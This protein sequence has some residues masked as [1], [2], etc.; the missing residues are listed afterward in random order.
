MVRN[1]MEVDG[2]DGKVTCI[3]K[4][5]MQAQH[6]ETIGTTGQ[7]VDCIIKKPDGVGNKS[8]VQMLEVPGYDLEL[9]YAKREG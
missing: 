5:I 6:A 2:K 4:E 7:Y 1:N 3:E 8:F 9:P